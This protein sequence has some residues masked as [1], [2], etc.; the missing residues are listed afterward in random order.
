MIKQMGNGKNDIIWD[1][2]N[3]DRHK[4][5]KTSQWHYLRKELHVF[6]PNFVFPYE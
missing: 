4:R 1:M 5:V 2:M 3:W 6:L